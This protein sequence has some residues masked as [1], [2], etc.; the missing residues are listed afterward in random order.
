MYRNEDDMI[1]KMEFRDLVLIIGVTV[2]WGSNYTVIDISL[3]GID[4]FI[5]T[6]LRFTFCALPLVF[7]IPKPKGVS[8]FVTIVYGLLFGIGMCWL[9]NYGMFL[10]VSAGVTSLLLQFSAFFTVI[11]GV[12][13]FGEKM[14]GIHVA[15]IL[16][17]LLGLMFIIHVTDGYAESFG[18]FLI[19][20][21]A[22]FWSL[23]NVLVKKSKVVDIFSFVVWSSLYATPPLYLMTYWVKGAAPF[24]TLLTDITAPVLVSVLF[25]AYVATVFGYWVWN[26]M[27]EKYPASQVAPLSVIVP[28]SGILTSWYVLDEP[29]GGEKLFALIITVLGIALFMNAS[30]IGRHI[31]ANALRFRG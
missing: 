7:F 28:I 16:M 23:C 25:Q 24:Q 4:P 12:L 11:W 2:M 6:A 18:L 19:L 1:K 13:L 15:G 9:M 30:R 29:I 10:G 22:F 31:A 8:T 14:T 26:R 5:L 3:D 17:A 27:I 20:L 21:G